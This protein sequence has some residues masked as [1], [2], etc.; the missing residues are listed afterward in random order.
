MAGVV[1]AGAVEVFLNGVQITGAN[2]QV[3]ENAKVVLDKQGNVHINA[4]DYKVSEVGGAK[5]A[6]Q[7]PAAQATN[8]QLT[9]KYY[10]VSEASQPGATGYSIQIIVNNKFLK[11]ISDDISQH[12]VELNNYLQEGNNTI[13]FRAIRADGKSAKSN[14]ASDYFSVI[15]GE[16]SG[17]QGSALTISDVLAEFKVTAIDQGEK[18]K[19][20][21]IKAK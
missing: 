3:I 2:D 7:P 11:T 4:P 20:F 17:T 9:K 19:S 18:S 12:I 16:G 1:P 14:K 5:S 10:V 21:S 15:L 8:A 13:S 6:S